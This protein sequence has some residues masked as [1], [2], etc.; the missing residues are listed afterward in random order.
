MSGRLASSAVGSP[1]AAPQATDAPAR[2]VSVIVAV[3]DNTPGAAE[4]I[5]H[6][7]R[8]TLPLTSFE[9]VV[10]DD[11]SRDGS[12]LTL[13]TDD[14][15]VR[16]VRG[17]PQT[18]YAARN[19]A[20]AAARGA[21]LAFCDSD[22]LPEP[23]WLKQ[24]LAALERADVVAGEVTFAAPE[25]PTVWS[26]LTIDM[27]LDQKRNVALSRGVTANLL[28]RRGLFDRLGGFD[29]SL[30]S[31]GDYDFVGRA[32][33]SGARLAYAP[34]AVVRHPTLDSRRLFLRKVWT[35]NR[36]RA[37]R[38]ARAR[39][40]PELKSVVGLLPGLGV[41]F[42]RREA[43]RPVWRL[44]DSRLQATGVSVGWRVQLRAMSL[45]YFVVAAVAGCAQVRGWLEG[46][47]MRDAFDGTG[48]VERQAPG[49]LGDAP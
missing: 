21:V 18:S 12:C 8:Q 4:L 9:V 43:L 40:R 49:Q 42:A 6:L 23:R 25:A 11:G 20:A 17:M 36:W 41:V 34:D 45:I 47:S 35:T 48:A 33:E 7:A 14:E 3:R 2:A 27:F 26:V 44:E 16:V 19:A 10:G 15:W 1:R 13:A 5:E 29:A 31:G 22:C 24:G 38:M 28:V 39:K 30:P 32:V 46:R 37:V